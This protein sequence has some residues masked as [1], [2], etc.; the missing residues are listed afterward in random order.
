MVGI[1]RVGVGV[2]LVVAFSPVHTKTI[3]SED[4]RNRRQPIIRLSCGYMMNMRGIGEIGWLV[5][6]VSSHRVLMPASKALMERCRLDDSFIGELFMGGGDY[7]Q[8]IGWP[9]L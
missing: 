5:R 8:A 6:D 2:G 7:G 3:A 1:R 4:I 9:L